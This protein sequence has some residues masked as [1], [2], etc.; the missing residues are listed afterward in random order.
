LGRIGEA[1]QVAEAIQELQRRQDRIRRQEFRHRQ[2]DAGE[3]S[4]A[5]L[6]GHLDRHLGLA[7]HPVERRGRRLGG[8]LGIDIG[9]RVGL[10]RNVGIV[11]HIRV[12]EIG[13]DVVEGRVDI[14]IEPAIRPARAV[15]GKRERQK[16]E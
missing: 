6:A 4:C 10:G 2:L 8:L 3:R 16:E 5:T 15:R 12:S 11:A 1:I 9:D 7:R 14:R 13:A